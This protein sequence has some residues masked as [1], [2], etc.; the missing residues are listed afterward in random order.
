[1]ATPEMNIVYLSNAVIPSRS[2]SS[3]HI[4][5][6]CRAMA[7]NGHD[8]HLLKID[9]SEP[10][11]YTRDPYI[12][13]SVDDN[14]SLHSVPW[15]SRLSGKYYL[16]GMM[17]ARKA[18][19]MAPDLIYGRYLF[20]IFV[21]ALMGQKVVFESHTDEFNRSKIHHHMI[22]FLASSDQCKRIVVISNALRDAYLNEY[23]ALSSKIVVA[24]D[25][26]DMKSLPA[27]NS[28]NTLF[29][30]GYVGSLFPGKGI[31]LISELVAKCLDIEF[32]VVGGSE[33]EVTYWRKK[34]KGSENIT[35]TGFLPHAE[36]DVELQKMDVVLAPYLK[37]VYANS[38][39]GIEISR[40]MSPM[41]IFEYMSARRPIVC[42]DLPVIRELLRNE[43]HALLCNPD[44]IE[45]WITALQRLQS[46]EQLRK[47]LSENAFQKLKHNYTWEK[48]A[49]NVL[50]ELD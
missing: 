9:S 2:A 31:E 29:T 25:G 27:K 50:V 1:M 7:S 16:Y 36:T 5:K 22:G 10:E 43:E 48:R 6:M 20:G 12:F 41:K 13:F 19:K 32:R 46:D 4:M 26:A 35:F 21:A 28:D 40:W 8:V 49:E 15:F 34:L 14:F 30:V 11:L 24:H 39:K 23:P 3:V 44:N 17:G 37:K 38:V 45:E 18:M 42:S 33:E 47:K